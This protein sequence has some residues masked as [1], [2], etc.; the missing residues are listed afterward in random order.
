MTELLSQA[1]P[2]RLL[3]IRRRHGP[4]ATRRRD[5]RG[6][7]ALGSGSRDRCP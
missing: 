6:S 1:E 2:L 3:L 4:P 7:P 5:H